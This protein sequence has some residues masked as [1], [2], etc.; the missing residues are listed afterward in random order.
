MMMIL[1]DDMTSGVLCENIDAQP[2]SISK[3]ENPL[4][5][6]QRMIF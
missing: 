6:H 2:S 1:H 3:H 5:K 4:R